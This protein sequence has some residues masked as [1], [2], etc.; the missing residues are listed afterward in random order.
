MSF[1]TDDYNDE[2]AK[3]SLQSRQRDLINSASNIE[4]QLAA[5]KG[6]FDVLRAASSPQKQAQ[7]DVKLQQFAVRLRTALG[8]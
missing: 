4:S 3:I 2:Q 1:D 6:S 8:F 5:F 7:L